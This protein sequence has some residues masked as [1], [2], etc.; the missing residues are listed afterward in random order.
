MAWLAN[1]DA[2][3]AALL[4]LFEA[5]LRSRRSRAVVAAVADLLPFVRGAMGVPRRGRVDGVALPPRE[6]RS[7]PDSLR[8]ERLAIPLPL[9]FKCRI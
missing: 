1:M 6:T 4:P 8:L 3:R 9:L 2:H 7:D 5:T